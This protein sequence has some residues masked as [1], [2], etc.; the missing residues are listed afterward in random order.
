VSGAI[1]A[2]AEVF[3]AGVCRRVAETC[4][5]WLAAGFVHGVLNSDNVNITGE[6]FDYGPWRFVPHFDPLFTAA[7]FD[8]NGLYAFARQPVALAWNLARLAECLSPFAD[9]A[10]LKRAQD[11]FTPSLQAGFR[12]AMLRRLGLK[13]RGDGADGKLVEALLNALI[14]SKAPFEQAIFD[15][16]CGP[17]GQDRRERSPVAEV[18]RG[19]AFAP[20]VGL[21]ADYEPSDATRLQLPYFMR[22]RPCTLLIEDVE[23]LWA[24]IAERDDWGPFQNKLTAI[25]EVRQAYGF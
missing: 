22:S 5:G 2:K 24:P 4:A 17:A 8:H 10:A 13:S 9:G 11:T 6:S 19:M 1:D 16:Y 23:A 20:V 18:Y 7:Y 3:L 21:L 12:R 15:F 25:D 14:A